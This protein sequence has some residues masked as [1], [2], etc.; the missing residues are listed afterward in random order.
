[1]SLLCLVEPFLSPLSF[2]RCE[3]IPCSRARR[4]GGSSQMLLG[5]SLHG[6][7]LSWTVWRL[8][9]LPKFHGIKTT[10][11][12]DL[13]LAS[14][15]T[16][17]PRRSWRMKASCI[18]VQLCSERALF[19]E[20]R[21]R[22]NIGVRRARAFLPVPLP[23]DRECGSLSPLR[24]LRGDDATLQLSAKRRRLS[25]QCQRRSGLYE[26]HHHPPLAVQRATSD[27]K[28]NMV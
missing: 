23:V 6:F 13:L 2:S 5:N 7:E 4:R 24:P 11:Q 22:H 14:R 21:R 28:G 25:A 12:H 16:S 8:L 20:R 27:L 17:R 10:M 19:Q 1:M 15:W 18:S 9:L 3:H 26:G